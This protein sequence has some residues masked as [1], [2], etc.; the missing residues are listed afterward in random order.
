LAD[1]HRDACV[2]PDQ[3]VALVGGGLATSSTVARAWRRGVEVRHHI[4]DPR[5]GDNP[6][7]V[8]RTA[9]VAARSCVDAN[10]ASTAAIV[11]GAGAPGWLDRRGLPSRLVAV[12]GRVDRVAGWP[13][14]EE[15]A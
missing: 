5:S 13:W 3:V 8:W 14:D 4:V 15:G 12:D 2:R 7:P 10:A 11:L 9:T 1:D 6:E